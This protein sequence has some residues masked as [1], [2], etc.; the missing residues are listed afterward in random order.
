[1]SFFITFWFSAPACLWIPAPEGDVA[2]DGNADADTDTDSDA[3]SDADADSD[4]DGDADSDADADT[5]TDVD[6]ETV[7]D[8][9][10]GYTEV[11]GDCDDGDIAV[12]PDA[13]EVCRNGVDDDC[14]GSAPECALEDMN[15][16]DADA[17]YTGENT[18]DLAGFAV[19]GAGDVN[20]DG[21]ADVLIGAPFNND[22][23]TGSG[24]AYLVLGSAS[25]G[26]LDL[27]AVAAKYSEDVEQSYVGWR[28]SGAGDVNADGFDDILVG[29]PFPGMDSTFPGAAYLVLG[30]G[31]PAGASLSAADAYYEGESAGCYAGMSV[32]NGGDVNGDG[33]GDVLVG[34]QNNASGLSGAAY[35]ILGSTSP[36]DLALASADAQY[37]GEDAGDN[38]STVSDA[39]DVDGDGLGDLLV[40]AVG[41][42]N[43]GEVAG[44]AYLV[45]GSASPGSGSLSAADAKYYGEATSDYAGYAL[46]S[47]GDVNGDGLADVVVGAYSNNAGG[48][49]AGAVYLILGIE[50]PSGGPLASA[51][52]KYTGQVNEQVGLS[53]SD[54]GDM[55]G[56]GFA[57]FVV[58]GPNGGSWG[59]VAYVVLGTP[60]PVGGSLVT[61]AVTFTGSAS[62]R[63]GSS[64]SGAGDVN[65]DG[66]GDLVIGAYQNDD[67]DSDAGAAYLILGNGL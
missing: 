37:V 16:A 32:S 50:S 14:S 63:A 44:A 67:A 28:V 33:F 17:E 18:N 10:D 1:M 15:L 57:D 52:A 21:Y 61:E 35:L 25:P 64:V 59:G 3:D 46:S 29:V 56:D 6:P 39:G 49:Y 34:A 62:E 40:G 36:S 53:V 4:T 48:T 54:A 41:G 58:G 30:S 38:A 31:S 9:G 7:D 42:I 26:D 23:G 22:N 5:D 12:N 66:L 19:S 24:A 8:D 13:T 2:T 20:D 27:S 65:L 11:G 60:G 47:A 51:D 43:A 55:D 45:L